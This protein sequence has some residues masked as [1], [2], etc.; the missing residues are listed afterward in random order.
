MKEQVQLGQ[1]V[2]TPV[3]LGHRIINIRKWK[4]KDR[5]NFKK[6]IQ[7]EEN[8]EK[9][10]IDSLVLN[11]IEG[12]HAFSPAEIQYLFVKIREISI[13]DTVNFEY[14]CK[15]CKKENK[16]V[17]K[18][19]DIQRMNFKPWG[20]VNGVKFGN[21]VNSKFYNENKDEEDDCKTLAFYTE[22]ING[23]IDKTFDE[24]VE[25][26]E[27]MDIDKFDEIYEEFLKESFTLDTELKLIC[28]KCGNEQVYEFDEI[29]GF[30]PD[31]WTK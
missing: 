14:T 21:I 6:A 2:Y 28:K 11:C 18:I 30:F 19:S 8:T 9:A 7:N 24:V 31:S 26:F 16:E 13:S 29:P 25:Y 10:I 20:E 17:L 23:E 5:K 27:E 3:D 4:G 1:P 22:S 12:T 15:A